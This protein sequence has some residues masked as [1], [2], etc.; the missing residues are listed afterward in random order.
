ML[1]CFD[2]YHSARMSAPDI[3]KRRRIKESTVLGYI[4]ECGAAGMPVEWGRLCVDARLGP[5][6]SAMMTPDDVSRAVDGCREGG[7]QVQNLMGE[8]RRVRMVMAQD[9]LTSTKLQGQENVMKGSGVTHAQIKIVLAMMIQGHGPQQW[10][11]WISV[12]ANK[13]QAVASEK[14]IAV[15]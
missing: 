8:T 13:G 6:S 12:Q 3:A 14:G 10:N 11:E 2:L 5:D 9:P 1:E 15:H 4:G 7:K